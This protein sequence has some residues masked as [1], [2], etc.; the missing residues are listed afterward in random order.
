MTERWTTRL[1]IDE[2]GS[3][4][5]R[6]L[7]TRR[8][9]VRRDTGYTWGSWTTKDEVEIGEERREREIQCPGKVEYSDKERRKGSE[10][11]GRSEEERDLS[12]SFSDNRS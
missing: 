10:N 11:M 2:K 4:E 9:G 3:H 7:T 8:D 12:K 1:D 6:L 5:G